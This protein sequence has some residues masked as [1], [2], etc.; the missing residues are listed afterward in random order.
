MSLHR[1]IS[2]C[3]RRQFDPLLDHVDQVPQVLV[4]CSQPHLVVLHSDDQNRAAGLIVPAESVFSRAVDFVDLAFAFGYLI[5]SEFFVPFN[6]IAPHLDD[7]FSLE[8]ACDGEPCHCVDVGVELV[9][10]G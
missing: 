10:F 9:P 1:T 7:L 5:R 3:L 6:P 2:T 8:F 4:C